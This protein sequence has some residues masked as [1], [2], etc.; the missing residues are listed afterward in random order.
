MAILMCSTCLS[1]TETSSKH[2]G[3]VAKCPKCGDTGKVVA[4][5]KEEVAK[6]NALTNNRTN[7]LGRIVLT[8]GAEINFNAIYMFRTDSLQ[9]IEQLR[10]DAIQKM[11][12][13]SSGIGF[14]GDIGYVLAASAAVGMLESV[15]NAGSQSKGDLLLQEYY[16]RR[17]DLRYRGEFRALYSIRQIQFADPA[18][19]VSIPEQDANCITYTLADDP[20]I[21]LRKNDGSPISVRWE[22]VEQYWVSLPSD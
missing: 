9:Q 1:S 5:P 14:I 17:L 22:S 21:C 11:T 12:P 10:Q 16:R 18:L 2:I 19:W 3:K 20:F 6:K 15:V 4:D 13:R 8:S 7:T